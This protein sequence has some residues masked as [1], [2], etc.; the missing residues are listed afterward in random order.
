MTTCRRL[1]CRRTE[2]S[3]NNGNWRCGTKEQTMGGRGGR[4]AMVKAMPSVRVTQLPGPYLALPSPS[5]LHSPPPKILPFAHSAILTPPP[6][7]RFIP[8]SA[9]S[10]SSLSLE[11]IRVLSVSLSSVSPSVFQLQPSKN[12]PVG[13]QLG[14]R[15]SMRSRA[16]HRRATGRA[17]VAIFVFPRSFSFFFYRF[18]CEDGF[19]ALAGQFS[20][21]TQ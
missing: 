6:P 13:L 20:L 4:A 16:F 10:P 19:V 18:R 8:L 3:T 7:S 17:I 11:G 9:S 14:R 2:R 1:I 5:F 12:L 15:L 21:I